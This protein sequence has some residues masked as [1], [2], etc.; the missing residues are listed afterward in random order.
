MKYLP[1]KKSVCNHLCD[2][3]VGNCICLYMQNH[4]M[5]E[6]ILQSSQVDILYNL[7]KI[8][9]WNFSILCL[10]I[11]KIQVYFS[12]FIYHMCWK[13]CTTAL[14]WVYLKKNLAFVLVQGVLFYYLHCVCNRFALYNLKKKSIVGYI[15]TFKWK[16]WI[17]PTFF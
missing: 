10:N 7:R 2:D 13:K 11:C 9:I 3:M 1:W 12:F 16:N 6:Y 5:T 4:N 8:C 17:C 15:H 14:F